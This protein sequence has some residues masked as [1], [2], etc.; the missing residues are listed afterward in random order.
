MSVFWH[1]C[2]VATVHDLTGIA[3][4]CDVTTSYLFPLKWIPLGHRLNLH[5]NNFTDVSNMLKS[6]E[7]HPAEPSD[8]DLSDVSQETQPKDPKGKDADKLMSM[9][10]NTYLSWINGCGI[11]LILHILFCRAE[12]WGDPACFQRQWCTFYPFYFTDVSQKTPKVKEPDA[13]KMPGMTFQYWIHLHGYWL[14]I[15]LFLN[16]YTGAQADSAHFISQ[17]H[18]GRTCRNLERPSLLSCLMQSYQW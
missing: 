4:H 9:P 2:S 8:A 15:Y 6:G 17:L 16:W 11:C 12:V 5:T 1:F 3:A 14:Y 10:G 7:T 18:T 13:D